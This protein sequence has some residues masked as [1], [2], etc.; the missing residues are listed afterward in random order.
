M[1]NLDRNEGLQLLVPGANDGGE[2]TITAS[3]STITLNADNAGRINGEALEVEDVEVEADNG[4]SVTVCASG[5][6]TGAVANGADLVVLCGGN[7]SGVETS[8]GGT[9]TT[10]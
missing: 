1:Q 8:S 10:S 5:T 9:V 2:A 4:A 3:V 7:V 6:V